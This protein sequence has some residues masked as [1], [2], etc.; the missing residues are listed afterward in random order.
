[1]EQYP[2]RPT[3]IDLDQPQIEIDEVDRR[4]ASVLSQKSRTPLAK[5]AE[6]IGLTTKTVTK[7]YRRLREINLLTRSTVTL[8]LNKLGYRALA[9]FYIRVSKRS[10]I[11]RIYCQLL[12]VSNLI[13]II[14]LIGSYDLYASVVLKDLNGL[15]EVTEKIRKINGL[16]S[17]DVFVTPMPPSWPLNLFPSLLEAEHMPKY[18]SAPVKPRVASKKVAKQSQLIIIFGSIHV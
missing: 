7:R 15:F 8:D 17:P 5:I 14:R 13:V 1:M 18:W 16:E 4:I 2:K 10:Q 11:E 12:H 3:C 6:Q 9:N